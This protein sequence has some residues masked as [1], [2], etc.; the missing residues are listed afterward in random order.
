MVIRS[1]LNSD[2]HK[3]DDTSLQQHV[4]TL[5]F[6]N[7]L[8]FQSRTEETFFEEGAAWIHAAY[9]KPVL[10]MFYEWVS[11]NLPSS[12]YTPDFMV[13]LTDHSL[14][15][16]EVKGSKNQRHYLPTRYKVRVAASL[17]PFFRFCIATPTPRSNG[18][19]IDRIE[20]DR[21]LSGFLLDRVVNCEYKRKDQS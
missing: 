15:F 10:A 16:V 11:F 5:N 12:T 3:L 19:D 21:K 7:L 6:K 1:S 13:M 14:V 18:W 9:N 2:I 20:Y 17:N 4:E 8:G